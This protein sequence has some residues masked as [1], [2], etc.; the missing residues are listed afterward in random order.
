[1]PT[2]TEIYTCV[3]TRS[4]HVAGQAWA[5]GPAAARDNT[6]LWAP[7]VGDVDGDRDPDVV[8][9]S[10]GPGKGAVI[11]ISGN[12]Q[13]LWEV[14]PAGDELLS[15]PVIADVSSSPGNAVAVGT[16]G[17]FHVLDGR[18]GATPRSVR[19][20]HYKNAAA[21]GEPGPGRWAAGPPA[22]HPGNANAGTNPR[23]DTRRGGT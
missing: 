1:M 18:S 16:G 8:V 2:R 3:N 11:A 22:L 19:A 12:G 6:S 17:R 14:E 20:G 15:S 5:G 13:P 4:L 7:A 23:P 9:G 21:G 10:C